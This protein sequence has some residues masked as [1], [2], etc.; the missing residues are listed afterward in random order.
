MRFVGRLR[1]STS[2]QGKVIGIV[3][4]GQPNLARRS[5][6]DVPE[7]G[8][9]STTHRTGSASDECRIDQPTAGGIELGEERGALYVW[10]LRLERSRRNGIVGRSRLTG[11][12]NVTIR[13]NRYRP[14]PNTSK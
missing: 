5:E 11:D 4:S 1:Q 14:W 2:R 10:K 12:I 9:K 3:A 6:L 8:A 7:V 13:V